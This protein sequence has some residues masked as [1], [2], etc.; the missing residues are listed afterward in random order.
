MQRNY[1]SG[2]FPSSME[3]RADHNDPKTLKTARGSQLMYTAQLTPNNE[4]NNRK[5]SGEEITPD[6]ERN[7]NPQGS[8]V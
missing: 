5:S 8:S 4:Q 3:S 2:I 1:Y 7:P 6:T